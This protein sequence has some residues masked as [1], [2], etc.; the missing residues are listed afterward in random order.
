MHDRR[1][2]KKAAPER[3]CE[4]SIKHS[5]LDAKYLLS[6]RLELEAQPP[7]FK[8]FNG[9]A[10]PYRTVRRRSRT[11]SLSGASDRPSPMSGDS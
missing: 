4:E 7:V 11:G 1:Q 6:L 8:R 9:K 10:E 3:L 2:L 5:S